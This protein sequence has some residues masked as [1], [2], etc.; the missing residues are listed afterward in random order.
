M[1]PSANL[2]G[3]KPMD[4]GRKPRRGF[5]P[6]GGLDPDARTPVPSGQEQTYANPEDSQDSHFPLSQNRYGDTDYAIECLSV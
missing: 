6:L 3:P 5:R 4:C 2:D 1:H